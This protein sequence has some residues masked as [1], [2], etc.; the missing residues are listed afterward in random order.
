MYKKGLSFLCGLL[1]VV[2]AITIGL[3]LSKF[4][5]PLGAAGWVFIGVFIRLVLFFAI[6]DGVRR[7]KAFFRSLTRRRER[8]VSSPYV[9]TRPAPPEKVYLEK[10]W[11][12]EFVLTDENTR[13]R[14][15]DHVRKNYTSRDQPYLMRLNLAYG[16]MER[17]NGIFL[18]MTYFVSRG[19]I[20][21]D[22]KYD[23]EKYVLLRG[24][25]AYMVERYETLS[26]PLLYAELAKQA[27]AHYENR[28]E[29]RTFEESRKA[30]DPEL[31]L[32]QLNYQ[33]RQKYL[34]GWEKQP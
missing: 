33:L 12:F 5:V 15:A 24:D 19:I 3:L 20:R 13:K 34:G 11:E 4:G 10:P 1:S 14:I 30:A 21:T 25:K 8:A 22:Y 26:A 16:V 7:V 31:N 9:Y 29:R 2:L 23:L 32:G 17:T 18:T 27:I 28:E 6:E